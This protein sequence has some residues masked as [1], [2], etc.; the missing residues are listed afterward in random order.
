MADIQSIVAD[1]AEEH[2]ELDA[3]VASLPSRAWAR[4]TPAETWTIADQISHLAHFDDRAVAALTDPDT[5]RAHVLAVLAAPHDHERDDVE[6]ARSLSSADLLAWWR[7]RRRRLLATV[8][9]SVPQRV[10]WYGPDMSV[11]SLVTARLMETWAHGQDIIDAIS[12]SRV[13]TARLRHICHLGLRALP[14]SYTNRGLTIPPDAVR[15]EL[16]APDG[17]T[18]HL[19]VRMATDVVRGPAVDFALVVTQ[20]RHR[21]DTSLETEGPIA[22]EWLTIAQAFAGRPGP[23]RA[24]V[25]KAE[26]G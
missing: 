19:G 5:F 26:R 17:S 23:G 3:V 16:V 10:P 7:E 4:S 18:W 1:L 8:S 24:P 25:L 6:S 14:F 13:P 2:A 15:A 9:C 20:R 12:R 11:A 22:A 21:H